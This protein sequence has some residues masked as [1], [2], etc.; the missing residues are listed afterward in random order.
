MKFIL[1]LTGQTGSG[2]T[3]LHSIAEDFGFFVIDCDKVAHKV[4]SENEQLKKKLCSVFSSDILLNGVI[5]RP[6]LAKAAFKNE[7]STKA[8]NE[9]VLPFVKAEIN[10]IIIR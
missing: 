6:K 1:G 8:L 10:D 3:T 4:L 7:E 5:S 2:K 9:T